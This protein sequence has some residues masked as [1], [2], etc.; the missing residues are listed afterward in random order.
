MREREKEERT[1]D[2]LNER[3]TI[4]I[5]FTS[6]VHTHTRTCSLL[7]LE[8]SER[9]NGCRGRQRGRR[10]RLAAHAES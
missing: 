6:C 7:E 3:Y 2:T 5:I 9:R 8:L 4:L 1:R 10:G